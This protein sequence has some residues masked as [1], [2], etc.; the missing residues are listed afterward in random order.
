MKTLLIALITSA[1]FSVL[2][3]SA[4]SVS[5]SYDRSGN[6]IGRKSSSPNRVRTKG[7]NATKTAAT[8]NINAVFNSV[9]KNIEITSK[10]FLCSQM[11]ISVYSASGQTVYSSII[12]KDHITIDASSFP[13]GIY[14]VEIECGETRLSR[15]VTIEQHEKHCPIHISDIFFTAVAVACT[16]SI[17]DNRQI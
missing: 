10:D 7:N 11:R 9:S 5:Y 6:R 4:Q 15:K 3:V 12:S 8:S 17:G 1:C 16:D 2:P 14:L 13:S